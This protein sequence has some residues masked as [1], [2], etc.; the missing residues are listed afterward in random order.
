VRV[1][2]SPASIAVVGTGVA[3]GIGV[4]VAIGIAVIADCFP[5]RPWRIFI[6]F[7]SLFS[8]CILDLFNDFI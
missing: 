5:Y 2:V 1:N 6:N 7:H 4:A 3:I 8:R